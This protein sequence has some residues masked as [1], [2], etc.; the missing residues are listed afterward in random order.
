M[1]ALTVALR[2]PASRFAAFV[3]AAGDFFM[4]ITEGNE[5]ARRYEILS[6]MSDEGLAA[7]GLTRETLAKAVIHGRS[8]L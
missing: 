5:M 8:G 4:G 7:R 6:R 1:T 3:R 2:A